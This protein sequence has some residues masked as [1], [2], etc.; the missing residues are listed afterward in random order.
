MRTLERIF[1][2]EEMRLLVALPSHFSLQPQLRLP[3]TRNCFLEIESRKVTE[4]S[5]EQ[6]SHRVRNWLC[7]IPLVYIPPHFPFVTPRRSLGGAIRLPR[8]PGDGLQTH[9]AKI[10]FGKR[11]I[12]V[13]NIKIRLAFIQQNRA[14]KS[15]MSVRK[16]QPMQRFGSMPVSPR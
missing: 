6:R 4:E 2:P 7:P 1:D 3:H 16:S 9:T 8:A 5:A 10:Q 11:P 12:N 14:N 13:A 15:L